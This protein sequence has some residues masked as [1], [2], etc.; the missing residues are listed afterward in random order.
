MGS[1]EYVQD[2][3]V[4]L[5]QSFDPRKPMVEV[6]GASF[7]ADEDYIFVKPDA[8]YIERELDWY[9]S[10]SLNVADFPGGAPKI[11]RECSSTKGEINSNYGYLFYSAEN[12]YQFQNVV[13]TLLKEGEGGRQA[14]AVYT[15]PT[16]HADSRRDGMRD[17]ICTNTVCYYLRGGEVSAVVQMRSNDAIFGYRNDLA[18][19]LYALYG[20]AEA[21]GAR[22]GEVYWQ[23]G[24]LHIYPRHYQAV[25]RH[26]LT[27][28]LASAGSER[29]CTRKLVVANVNFGGECAINGGPTPCLRETP[30]RPPSADYRDCPYPHAEMR[31]LSKLPR[32][33]TA[34]DVVWVTSPPCVPCSR[35][36]VAA[37]AKCVVFGYDPTIDGHLPMDEIKNILDKGGVS[38]LMVTMS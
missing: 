17:F 36:L 16:I 7:I 15:R 25:A 32:P 35:G 6:L 18:W 19:Q 37:G 10:M 4:E 30:G 2:I 38:C 11:W 34:E 33:L 5:L 24:S 13:D 22:P 31:L 14:T 29:R 28:M 27:D 12:G 21:V 20:V 9:E 1:I 8:G 23:A 26:G 3:R